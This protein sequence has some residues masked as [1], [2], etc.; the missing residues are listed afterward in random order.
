MGRLS[1]DTA[2]NGAWRMN[3]HVLLQRWRRCHG[4]ALLLLAVAV[5]GGVVPATAQERKWEVEVHGGGMLA[6]NNPTEGAATLPDPGAPFTTQLGAASRRVSSWY[7]G[8][9][10]LLRVRGLA[11]DALPVAD[12][13]GVLP[14]RLAHEGLQPLLR[15][16]AAV[17][18]QRAVPSHLDANPLH[19]AIVL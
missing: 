7:F 9:G 14:A 11:A 16:S 12:E 15:Q 17:D 18:E 1:G 3:V 8:D 4:P 10:A 13:G 2:G 5:F 19:A 6:A